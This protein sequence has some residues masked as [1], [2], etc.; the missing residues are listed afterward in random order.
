MAGKLSRKRLD[1]NN[2]LRFKGI[3]FY[4]ASYGYSPSKDST[5]EF[6]VTSKAGKKE[7]I[8][9]RF[10]GSFTIPGTEVSGRVVDFS[11]ALGVDESGKLY[12]YADMMNNPAAFVE[13]SEHGAVKYRQ[14]IL[15]RDPHTWKVGD[16]VVEFTHLW[17]AQ[18]TGLQV[19]KD[20][21]VW[22][23]YLGC[24]IMAVVFMLRS[25]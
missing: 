14:W 24:L 23:V 19:R 5:F 9:V 22:I 17:G 16:G 15:A 11:P 3:T 12:T 8:N 20:P 4:Q 10:G 2:P 6:T 18:Y 1:V 7:D 21:G 25:S 13:F